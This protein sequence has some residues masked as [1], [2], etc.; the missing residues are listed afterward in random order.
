MA[1]RRQVPVWRPPTSLSRF[2]VRQK[3]DGRRVGFEPDIDQESAVGSDVVL[4]AITG[5]VAATADDASRE[6][7]HG[8]A[9]L[10]RRARDDNLADV[11]LPSG[12]RKNSSLPS[13]LHRG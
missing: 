6:E 12:A 13:G 9:R 8:D 7:R 3:P 4:L 1:R 11:S 2:P 10:D 5:K